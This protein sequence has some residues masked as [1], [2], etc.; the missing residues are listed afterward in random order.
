MAS[1]IVAGLIQHRVFDLTPIS[2]ASDLLH[3]MPD[4]EHWVRSGMI[5]RKTRYPKKNSPNPFGRIFLAATDEHIC[6]AT[7]ET[8]KYCTDRYAL[9]QV[10]IVEH[11]QDVQVGSD[12]ITRYFFDIV[13]KEGTEGRTMEF[14]ADSSEELETWLMSLTTLAAAAQELHRLSA[15]GRAKKKLKRFHDSNSFQNVTGGA[16]VI[17]FIVSIVETEMVPPATS[18]D[19]VA[20]QWV[21][22]FLTGFFCIELFITFSAHAGVEFF[23]DGWRIFDTLTVGMSL[24]ALTVN[25]GPAKSM[26]ALRVLRSLRLSRTSKRL[27][28]TLDATIAAVLPVCNALV[29]YGLVTVIYASIAVGLFGDDE[30]V[31]FGRLSRS[32]FT[33]FQVAMGDAWASQIVREMYDD[34]VGK[35]NAMAAVPAL[36]F[37]SYMLICGV[38]LLNVVIAVMLD[39]FLTTM[40]IDRRMRAHTE[41]LQR[42]PELGEAR[43][44]EPLV[45]ILAK[46]RSGQDL[47]DSIALVVTHAR[48]HIHTHPFHITDT[49]PE[50]IS[51]M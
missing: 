44:L 13:P 3:Q 41:M 28:P 45:K 24:V 17:S 33:M 19:F 26:R 11:V 9:H 35:G 27:R 48:T 46:F 20:F 12:N 36:M 15:L 21:D 43:P 38:V 30:E 25:M 4:K 42:N 2:H 51:S 39:T 32:V 14:E 8:D 40:T 34:D 50:L 37:T 47:L 31:L 6:I 49:T 5:L 7:S 29:I 10:K 16:I 1:A 18:T 23:K 22:Y